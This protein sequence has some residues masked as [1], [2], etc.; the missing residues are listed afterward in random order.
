MGTS[1]N[2]ASHK[3]DYPV[4]IVY[5]LDIDTVS[6]YNSTV[7]VDIDYDGDQDGW[8]DRTP[9]DQPAAQGHWSARS[10]TQDGLLIVSGPGDL[11]FT[12]FALSWQTADD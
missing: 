8:Y 10:F 2:H 11:P 3:C 9:F 7:N 12:N 5:A 4:N 6:Y 1:L